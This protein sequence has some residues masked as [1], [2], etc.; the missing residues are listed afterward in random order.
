MSRR[1]RGGREGPAGSDARR[2]DHHRDRRFARVGV[3]ESALP[4]AVFAAF[5]DVRLANVLPA[6]LAAFRL[7]WRVFLAIP[8]HLLPYRV[9]SGTEG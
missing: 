1:G 4:A 8:V 6:A 2:P 3:C 9:A 7:V 5:V